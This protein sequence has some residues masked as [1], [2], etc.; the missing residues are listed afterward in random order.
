[1]SESKECHLNN[2]DTLSNCLKIID[3]ASNTKKNTHMGSSHGNAYN[4]NR[5]R[6]EDKEMAVIAA[7]VDS[8]DYFNELLKDEH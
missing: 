5:Q 4:V 8:V 3:D 2:N 1:M 6:A 7:P